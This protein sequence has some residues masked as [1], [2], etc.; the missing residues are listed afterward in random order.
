V[1]LEITMSPNA[2]LQII[3][4]GVASVCPAGAA[5]CDDNSSVQQGITVGGSLTPP[6]TNINT[7]TGTGG[8]GTGTGTGTGS[9]TGSGTGTGSGSG[10]GTGTGT[11]AATGAGTSTGTGTGTAA[12]TGTGA[13]TNTGTGT[14]TST[15]CKV[16]GDCATGQTCCSGQCVNLTSD[17]KNC[18]ACGTQCG[19]GQI[20]CGAG[21]SGMGS[22]CIVDPGCPYVATIGQFGPWDT[23][24]RTNPGY[25]AGQFQQWLAQHSGGCGG[26]NIPLQNS[27]GSPSYLTYMNPSNPSDLRTHFGRA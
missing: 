5:G 16:N 27:D 21:L 14:G 26:K 1:V 17:T 19:T 25:G 15:G 13:G 23:N 4:T 2:N 3:Q 24:N 7:G 18:G 6:P 8:G 12:G 11:A 20:C 10:T 22:T 9:G